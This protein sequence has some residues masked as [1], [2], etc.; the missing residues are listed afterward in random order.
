MPSIVPKI[1]ALDGLLLNPGDNPW[2]PLAELGELAVYDRTA[3]DELLEHARDADVLVLNKK[4]LSAAE[5]ERLPRLKFVTMTA[6][7][8]NMVD[9]AAARQRG[10][11]VSNVPEYGSRTVAQFAF[12]LLLELCH[13]VGRHAQHVA[14][15][16]WTACPDF[17]Y[18]LTPQRELAGQ[19][20]TIVGFGRI[21]GHVAE[22]ARAF[23]MQVLAAGRPGQAPAS[24]GDVRREEFATALRAADVVSLHCPLTPA[25]ERLIDA[26]R[27]ELLRPTALLINTSR[28]GLIDEPALAAALN[29]ERLG[30]AGLDVA[31]VEPMLPENPLRT[32]K[33]CLMTPHMAWASLAA[34]RRLLQAAADN[35][36]AFL[37]GRPQHVVN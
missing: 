16:G 26:R 14:E 4:S 24:T 7:G 10:I 1:V 12:A 36:R 18:W 8:Y 3:P 22:I 20:L 35:V 30:G 37:A 33:N 25:T 5:I 19:T 28:G 9:V 15:G 32:A 27:L 21:G 2:D 34:R 17:G 11:P 23:G 29:A 31:A 6:T 13:H